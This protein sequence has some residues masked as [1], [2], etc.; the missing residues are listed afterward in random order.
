MNTQISCGL[1]LL[2]VYLTR[3]KAGSFSKERFCKLFRDSAAAKPSDFKSCASL[4]A[5]TACLAPRFLVVNSAQN[6]FC[7]TP[8]H[9]QAISWTEF[10][11]VIGQHFYLGSTSDPFPMERSSVTSQTNK[12]LHF[13]M[14]FFP[15]T[16]NTFWML[17]MVS[18]KSLSPGLS[19]K[20]RTLYSCPV[21]GNGIQPR[22]FSFLGNLFSSLWNSFRN[23]LPRTFPWTLYPFKSL[24]Q[25]FHSNITCT[26]LRVKEKFLTNF[27]ISLFLMI[28]L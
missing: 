2:S 21:V 26:V 23:V 20:G 5:T 17:C 6:F 27:N 10:K 22:D 24:S 7:W 16:G 14:L 11:I 1:I 12:L 8:L 9:F 4:L 15:A 25:N 18:F 13:S 28:F 3:I 19:L